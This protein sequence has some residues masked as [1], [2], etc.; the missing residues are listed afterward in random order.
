M[1]TEKAANQRFNKWLNENTG[2]FSTIRTGYG[3]FDREALDMPNYLE[4]PDK[5][6]IDYG[7]FFN[8]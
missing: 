1:N 3:S 5:E 7:N 2:L 8:K 6:V 4:N